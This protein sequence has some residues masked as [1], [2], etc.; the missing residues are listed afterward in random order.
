MQAKSRKILV[1]FVL[2]T[3]LS[4]LFNNLSIGVTAEPASEKI[5]SND[6][7]TLSAGNSYFYYYNKNK[8]KTR[9]QEEA[10]SNSPALFSETAS[11]DSIDGRSCVVLKNSG[12]WAEWSFSV[13]ESGVYSLY[14]TYYPVAGNG[15]NI[16]FSVLIDG[17]LPFAEAEA[18][19]LPRIWSDDISNGDAFEKDLSGNEIRPKSI[20]TPRWSEKALSDV[21]GMYSEPY[22]FYFEAGNHILRIACGNEPVAFEKVTFKNSDVPVSYN[23]YLSAFKESDYAQGDVIRQETEKLYE[24]NSS[25]ISVANDRSTAATYPNDPYYTKLNMIGGS[26]WSTCGDSISW[27]VDVDKPGLYKIAFR[28]CQNYSDGMNAYRTLYVNGAVPFVEAENI[29]FEYNSGWYVKTLGDSN[30]LMLYLKNGDIITLECTSGEMDFPLREIQQAVLDLNV[31][32][33]D[34]IMITGPSPS[35]YQDYNLEDQ[36]PNLVTDL[37]NICERLDMA[38]MAIDQS[39]DKNSSASATV[40]KAVTIFKELASDPFFIIDRLSS[41][42]NNIESLA[43]LL[44]SLGGQ[45]VG[46]DCIYYV[47]NGAKIPDGKVGFIDSVEFGF[48]RFIVT[49][50][51]DYNNVTTLN[52]EESTVINVWTGIGRDQAQILNRLIEEDFTNKTGISVK[53]GLVSGDQT[54]IKATLAGKGP[55]VCLTVGYTTPINL[56]ARGALVDLSQFDLSKLKSEIYPS[57]WTLFEYQDGIYAVPENQTCDVMFYRTDIFESMGLSA[58]ETWDDFYKVLQV[59]QSKNLQ[60]A[61]P[62]INS[63]DQGNSN[64]INIFNKFLFQ[65]GGDYYSNDLS[66]TM[67]DTEEAYQAFERTIELYRVYGLER[68]VNQFNRFRSGEAPLVIAAY[69]LYTQLVSSAPE[70]NGLWEIAPIP[71]TLK[72]DGTIDRTDGAPASGCVMMT[73]AEENGVADEC[74]SFMEWWAGA[75]TQTEYNRELEGIL[76]ILGRITPSNSVALKNIGWSDK[77]LSVIDTQLSRSKNPKQVVGNYQVSRSLTSAIRSAINDENTA[78]R[79]LQLYNKDINAE[80]SRKRKEFR[81]D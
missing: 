77:A 39:T 74:F 73:A 79:A 50:T 19:T 49:F 64:A 1:L 48:K 22:L 44:L 55:D 58:P 70:I 59:L 15:N 72:E 42:K 63:A 52:E 37:N 65:N 12:D 71:G 30:P 68:D 69:S 56:A 7:K 2:L 32:Y 5:Q 18:F 9:I 24:K 41:F 13:P 80:I 31:V 4:T 51:E 75:E 6:I 16:E 67:F 23:E 43:S 28:A 11:K 61:W 46:L 33:R 35:I 34:I 14:P 20:E 47:P 36:L 40:A 8:D 38:A 54:L 81:L 62:E 10:V 45:A 21:L 29:V 25:K 53:L 57:A 26:N 66:A 3:Y 27:K 76:G 60:I 17:T 78:R